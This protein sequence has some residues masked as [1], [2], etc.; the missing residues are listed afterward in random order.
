MLRATDKKQLEWDVIQKALE[1]EFHE[2]EA[3]RQ[4]D[5]VIDWGRYAEILAYDDSS[6]VLFLEPGGATG[7][8]REN[9]GG[10]GPP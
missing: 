3:E 4:L 2:E 6:Q 1:L 5:T 8:I 9:A 10:P 7:F